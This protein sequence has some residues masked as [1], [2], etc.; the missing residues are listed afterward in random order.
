M[1]RMLSD[2]PILRSGIYKGLA[3]AL[4]TV[5]IA[6]LS[7]PIIILPGIYAKYF[8]ISL[9]TIAIIILVSRLFDAISDPLIGYLS[10]R[11]KS[12]LGGRKR[13]ILVGGISFIISSFFLYMPVGFETE[14]DS[15]NISWPYLLASLLAFYFSWTC[16]QIP[17]L[18]WGGEIFD[19]A[20]ERNIVYSLRAAA[21][22]L[23]LLLFF[24]LPL[25]PFWDS[26]E[27]TPD[28]LVFC[29]VVA[30]LMMLPMILICLN[31]IP[32]H[33]MS[34]DRN[35][36][37]ATFE[38]R[39]VHKVFMTILKN[40]PFLTFTGALLFNGVAM[41]MW[42]G[43]LFIYVDGYLG[44]GGKLPLA[45]I[46]GLGGS[47]LMLVPWYKLADTYGKKISWIAGLLFVVIGICFSAFIEPGESAWLYLIASMILISGGSAATMMLAP[48]LLADI[49]DYSSW[50]FG[51][52]SGATYFSLYTLAGKTNV[53]IGGSVGL[54]IIGVYGFDPTK[55]SQSTEALF[56]LH[57]SMIWVPVLFLLLSIVL[58]AL[59]PLNVRQHNIIRV[60]QDSLKVRDLKR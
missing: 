55:S 21:F 56:G 12:R 44:I 2:E 59:I 60:R 24:T 19:S 41:G 50:R 57:L 7:G 13:L 10:D 49:I 20:R 8:G 31:A 17:Y 11:F 32:D 16:F 3:Y 23:G 1:G 4:P 15:I 45:L 51:Q 40:K 22:Y 35:D 6:F 36:K 53:A 5:P 48:S 9:T 28:I 54:A 52:A 25:L 42:F 34:S 37:L 58:I 26:Q 39:T 29:V 43:L 38:K 18:A 47:V 14:T 46:L 27:F 33:H 30:F